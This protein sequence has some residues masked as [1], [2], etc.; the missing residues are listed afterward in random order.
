MNYVLTCHETV[1]YSDTMSM[2]ACACVHAC[3]R[4]RLCHLTNLNHLIGI[5]VTSCRHRVTFVQSMGTGTQNGRSVNMT[6]HLH[7]VS[8]LRM[9]GAIP[10]LLNTYSWRVFNSAMDISHLDKQRG[11]RTTWRTRAI[12][13]YAAFGSLAIT[14]DSLT[15]WCRIFEKLI[16]IHIIKKYPSFMGTEGSLPCSQKPA[17]GSYPEP[18]ESSSPHRSLS[19]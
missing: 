13:N 11:Q 1:R 9:R 14:Y 15:P 12:H 8:R 10:P 4:A 17:T 16:V 2:C 19:P 6:T 7:L 5:R 3:T 18:A